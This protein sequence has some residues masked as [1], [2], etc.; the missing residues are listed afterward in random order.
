MTHDPEGRAG[1]V[2]ASVLVVATLGALILRQAITLVIS[3]ADAL[4]SLIRKV[5]HEE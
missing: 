1:A 3:L 5:I 2:V 4:H